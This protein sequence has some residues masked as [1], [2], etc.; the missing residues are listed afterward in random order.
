MARLGSLHTTHVLLPRQVV[1]LFQRV[2]LLWA[3]RDREIFGSAGLLW[4]QSANRITEP[5]H[6]SANMSELCALK[7]LMLSGHR[8]LQRV[9]VHLESVFSRIRR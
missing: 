8:S 7:P 5:A 2:F 4:C 9:V 1:R 3:G 6:H